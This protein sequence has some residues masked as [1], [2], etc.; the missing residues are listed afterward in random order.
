[1]IVHYE[2]TQ[3][4][5]QEFDCDVPGVDENLT[6]PLSFVREYLGFSAMRTPAMF[7]IDYSDDQI[8]VD[9]LPFDD[10]SRQN[11]INV[12][13]RNIG[14]DTLDGSR[15]QAEIHQIMPY[16]DKVRTCAIYRR[17]GA[18]PDLRVNGGTVTNFLAKMGLSPNGKSGNK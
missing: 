5:Q 10:T 8:P 13:N 1:M 3:I 4:S 14:V 11:P 16:K 17:A 7:D 6:T 9:N 18:P 15:L 12:D 2:N